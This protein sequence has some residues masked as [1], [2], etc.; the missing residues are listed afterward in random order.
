M[1]NLL[2]KAVKSLFSFIL[3]LIKLFIWIPLFAFVVYL[4]I[5]F[6]LKGGKN[7]EKSLQKNFDC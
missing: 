4:N 1:L 6:F 2:K 3:N 5:K 7:D